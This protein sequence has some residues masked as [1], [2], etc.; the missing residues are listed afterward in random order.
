MGEN[1]W[2]QFILAPTAVQ[3]A[4]HAL[5]L[6]FL[7]QEEEELFPY[8][9]QSILNDKVTPILSARY[10][11]P[12]RDSRGTKQA[13]SVVVTVDPQHFATLTS[14]VVILSQTCKVELAFSASHSFQCRNC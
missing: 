10:L 14:G 3:L 6:R 4:I 7:R 13:T 12:S 9:R 11:N 1:P 8:L 2:A 5:P